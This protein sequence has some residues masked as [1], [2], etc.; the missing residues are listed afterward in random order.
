MG[1]CS[2]FI[3]QSSIPAAPRAGSKN[4]PVLWEAGN[5]P[6]P[7]TL[8][9]SH[10]QFHLCK[11]MILKL[12]FI[13]AP[14]RPCN[15]ITEVAGNVRSRGNVGEGLAASSV[16]E[17]RRTGNC[18]NFGADPTFS[19][20]GGGWWAAGCGKW[21]GGMLAPGCVPRRGAVSPHASGTAEAQHRRGRI[22]SL[23]LV[24]L[25]AWECSG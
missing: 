20:A 19:E 6:P 16:R 18:G 22:C 8:P 9:C 1:F 24:T 25:P 23:S 15:C 14:S 2:A 12:G 5:V 4:S 13:Q 21:D 11:V 10:F 7:L 17:G 3:Q